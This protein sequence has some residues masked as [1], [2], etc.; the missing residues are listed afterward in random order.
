MVRIV[1]CA[2]GLGCSV[3]E[4][5]IAGRR[6]RLGCSFDVGGWGHGWVRTLAAQLGFRP[7][8]TLHWR[9]LV[10]GCGLLEV[11]FVWTGGVLDDG[12][13]CWLKAS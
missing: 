4:T 1:L 3:D 10:E 9:I 8:P 6:K 5:G 12:W 7:P 13:L 2:N 11:R